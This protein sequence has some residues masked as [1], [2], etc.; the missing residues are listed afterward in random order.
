LISN[1]QNKRYKECPFNLAPPSWQ[2]CSSSWSA[3]GAPLGDHGGWSILLECLWWCFGSCSCCSWDEME[4]WNS[5]WNGGV[6]GA[7]ASGNAYLVLVQNS[8]FT[9]LPS[10]A[11][12]DCDVISY[13]HSFCTATMFLL[14]ANSPWLE[15]PRFN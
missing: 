10:Q 3:P 1:T 11:S 15:W 5:E 14:L 9:C 7:T 2:P 4:W 12:H 13:W 8:Y 6:W